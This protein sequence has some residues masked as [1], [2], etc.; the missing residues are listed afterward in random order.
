MSILRGRWMSERDMKL[1]NSINAEL[2]G[3]MI[4]TEVI[5]Y[6][7]MPEATKINIYG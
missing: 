7:Q 4:Q 1:V 3:D 2:M 6:K 5:M